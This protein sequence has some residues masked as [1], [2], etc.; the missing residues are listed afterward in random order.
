MTLNLIASRSYTC[1]RYE[2]LD[3][4]QFRFHSEM[5]AGNVMGRGF[6]KNKISSIRN[7]ESQIEPKSVCVFKNVVILVIFTE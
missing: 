5:I 2:T 4:L 1:P 3:R 6:N 7:N